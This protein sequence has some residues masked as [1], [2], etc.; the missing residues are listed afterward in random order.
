M[1]NLDFVKIS[2]SL[3]NHGNVLKIYRNINAMI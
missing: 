3:Q 2:N 1:G